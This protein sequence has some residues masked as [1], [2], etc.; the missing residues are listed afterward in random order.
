MKFKREERK[1]HVSREQV[2][3]TDDITL[4]L[5]YVTHITLCNGNGNMYIPAQ[6]LLTLIR[7]VLN[8]LHYT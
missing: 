4:T 5:T 6:L 8:P 1:N 7:P 2:S 3:F